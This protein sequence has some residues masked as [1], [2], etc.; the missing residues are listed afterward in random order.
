VLLYSH[1][2]SL[3]KYQRPASVGSY[4]FGS[5][6]REHGRLPRLHRF[7]RTAPRFFILWTEPDVHLLKQVEQ[8]A[9]LVLEGPARRFAQDS[10][11]GD[12][13]AAEVLVL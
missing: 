1:E 11:H 13:G 9:I 10:E 7:R 5:Y 6:R 4:Q 2:N 8:V 3:T 12:Q